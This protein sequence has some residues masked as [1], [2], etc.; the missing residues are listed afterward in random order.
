MA[1]GQLP[2]FERRAADGRLMGYQVKIRKAGFPT[3][4]RQFDKLTDAERFALDQL[5]AMT[6][7]TWTDLR[8]AERTTLAAALDRYK[9]EVTPGNKSA[10][11]EGRLIER[12]KATGLAAYSLATI[13]GSD[14][15][16]RRDHRRR[17]RRTDP[18]LLRGLLALGRRHRLVVVGGEEFGSVG[19][20]AGV[21]EHAVDLSQPRGGE[22]D[23]EDLTDT[24]HHI[25]TEHFNA[26][27]REGFGEALSG[28]LGVEFG[29]GPRLVVLEEYGQQHG[30]VGGC[31]G[32]AYR[33]WCHVLR[34]GRRAG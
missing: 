20:P 13:Q 31:G 6:A 8:E 21:F 22:A 34:G 1:R 3:V 11:G 4:S 12:F 5:Q 17:H 16:A 2:I 29:Q 27:R 14:I 30:V 24:H 26:G 23:G 9:R 10:Y 28:Q 25:P 32:A 15:A 18:P 7:R 33:R 19:A